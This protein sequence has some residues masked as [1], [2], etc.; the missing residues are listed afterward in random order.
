LVLGSLALPNTLKGGLRMAAPATQGRLCTGLSDMEIGDYI[1]CVYEAP[2]ANTAGTFS[3]LGEENPMY[4]ATIAQ[5]VVDE[6][7]DTVYEEDGTT[8]KTEMVTVKTAYPELPATAKG[9]FYFIKADKGLWIADRKIQTNIC[10]SS[11]NKKNYLHGKEVNGMLIRILSQAEWTKYITNSDFDGTIVKQAENVWHVGDYKTLYQRKAQHI[12]TINL[13][14]YVEPVSNTHI[15]KNKMVLLASGETYDNEH[16]VCIDAYY[17][18]SH[19]QYV[20]IEW[21]LNESSKAISTSSRT[22]STLGN[23]LIINLTA[24]V[25][26]RPVLEAIDNP[27]SKTIFY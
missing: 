27:K 24:N 1:K 2:A 26:Y 25:C 5:N 10:A 19:C 15:D 8:P 21:P 14:V 3:H 7:G 20:P 11:L 18:G 12:E 13:T 4:E 17:S 16:L 6:N 22:P 9:Y 23:G